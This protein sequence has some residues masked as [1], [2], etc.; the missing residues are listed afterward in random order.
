MYVH[1]YTYH[2][3]SRR[4][5]L[6]PRFPKESLHRRAALDLRRMRTPHYAAASRGRQAVAFVMGLSREGG[7]GQ[8]V[9]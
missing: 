4:K 1:I 2:I 9:T 8:T 5:P 6:Q 7:R 3:I